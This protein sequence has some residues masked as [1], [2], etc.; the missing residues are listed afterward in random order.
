[1]QHTLRSRTHATVVADVQ[2]SRK[3]SKAQRAVGSSED[4]GGS[5]ETTRSNQGESG[6]ARRTRSSEEQP[7]AATIRSS[8]FP[9]FLAV[10][11]SGSQE[12]AR[13]RDRHAPV[14]RVQPLRVLLRKAAMRQ[15]A[16]SQEQPGSA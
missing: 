11:L 5:K 2:R 1:M 3:G 15:P 13:G 12:P 4:P 10:Q 7:G 6:G 8:C 16:S 9:G 14:R